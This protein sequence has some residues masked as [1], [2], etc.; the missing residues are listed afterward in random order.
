MKIV[1][2][3]LGLFILFQSDY[4]YSEEIYKM[5]RK[6]MIN[7]QLK[8]RGVKDNNVLK[9]VAQ[10]ERHRFVPEQVESLAYTDRPLPIGYDQT[11]SQPYIVAFMTEAAG[12]K[13]NDKVLEIGTGSG[14]QA[15]VLAEIADQVYSIEIVKE[16]A[17]SAKQKLETLGYT[18][19]TV[20]HGDGYQGW[21]EHAPFDVVIVTAAPDEIPPRLIEQLKVGGRMI[22][23][24]GTDYQELLRIQKTK[25]GIK[26][27][28]L[29]PVRFVPMIKPYDKSSGM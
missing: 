7:K 16:L 4:V 21:S 27:E 13:T 15:A 29:L 17:V 23:P 11:I 3:F 6:Q 2:I 25:N 12:L 1:Y 9:A 26:Q 22:I 19:V 28:R 14:Y 24:V 8:A 20:K 10:I 5:Q 18:N